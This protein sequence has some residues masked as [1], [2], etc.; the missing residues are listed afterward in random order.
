MA[1]Q[2]PQ[3]TSHRMLRIVFTVVQH[4]SNQQSAISNQQSAIGHRISRRSPGVDAPVVLPLGSGG[5]PD[6]RTPGGRRPRDPKLPGRMAIHTHAAAG[7]SAGGAQTRRGAWRQVLF[8]PVVADRRRRRGSDGLK[9]GLAAL[10]LLCCVLAVGY[11]SHFDRVIAQ[12]VHPP[13]HSISWLI[14]FIYDAGSFGIT[15]LLI[16]LALLARRWAV[17]R[18]IGLSAAGAA[19]LSGLLIVALGSDGG[20]SLGTPINGF[21]LHFPVVQIAVFMSVVTAALPYLART[22]QRAIEGFV[23]LVALASVVGGH[24]L[25]VNVLGSLALGWGVTA[26]VHLI[27]GSHLGIPSGADVA[28][29]VAGLGV[30]ARDVRAAD[31]QRWGV[32]CYEGT[33]TG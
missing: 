1:S 12:T 11:S 31:D 28:A 29:L 9:A 26:M 18:D 25:P 13:P 30:G 23:L 10:S 17:A 4:G 19:A 22:V 20:R 14:T 27:F 7:P 3:S 24:G 6:N 33:E 16:V 32:A 5:R 8:A 2:K 21:D 15:A